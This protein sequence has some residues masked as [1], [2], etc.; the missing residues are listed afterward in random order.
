MALGHPEAPA[1]LAVLR[2]AAVVDVPSMRLFAGQQSPLLEQSAHHIM[3]IVFSLREGLDVLERNNANSMAPWWLAASSD[4]NVVWALHTVAALQHGD[5]R[6][7][8]QSWAALGYRHQRMC[9]K[10]IVLAC[11]LAACLP[12]CQLAFLLACWL[13]F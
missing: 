1:A 8:Y 5:I 12:N 7:N 6:A 3:E 10:W 11:W 9:V 4:D 13:E 2:R